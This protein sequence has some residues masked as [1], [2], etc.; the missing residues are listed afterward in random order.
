MSD[1]ESFRTG[2]SQQ[3][4]EAEAALV[5]GDVGPRLEMWSHQ[6]PV[7]LFAAVGPSK[8]GW[9]E[10]EPTFRSVASRLSGGRDVEYEIMEFDVTRDMAWTA[11]FARFFVSMDGGPLIHRTLRITHVYRREGDEWKV[12]HE[13]SNFEPTDDQTVPEA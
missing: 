7:S 3:Q 1:R 9:G 10:L 6:D 8:S 12:V 4:H 13:H 11:G 5:R 2:I